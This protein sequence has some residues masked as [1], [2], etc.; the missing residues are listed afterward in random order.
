MACNGPTSIKFDSMMGGGGGGLDIS[1][2]FRFFIQK[3]T[4][5]MKYLKVLFYLSFFK[6]SVSCH[7]DK[8]WII[9]TFGPTALTYVFC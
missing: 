2:E 8:F 1:A 3:L 5:S 4:V 9:R 6:Q 7:K